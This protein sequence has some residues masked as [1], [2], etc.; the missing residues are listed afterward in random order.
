[1]NVNNKYYHY[2]FETLNLEKITEKIREFALLVPEELRLSDREL[3]SLDRLATLLSTPAT[4]HSTEFYTG[5]LDL[6]KK[7]LGWP[8]EHVFPV[9]DMF[10]IFVLHPHSQEMFKGADYGSEYT[11]PVSSAIYHS[12]DPPLVITA[13]RVLSNLF[14]NAIG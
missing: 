11:I 8:R 12:S 7:L 1:M 14:K 4:Y 2:F 9:L 13:L 6:I 3:L 5:E 10:R